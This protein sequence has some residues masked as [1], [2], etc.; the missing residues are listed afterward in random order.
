[1]LSTVYRITVYRITV[2]R[3]A[4]SRIAVLAAACVAAGSCACSPTT[5][6]LGSEPGGLRTSD[7]VDFSRQIRPLLSRNCFACHGPDTA[8][9]EADLR[10]DRFDSAT[11]ELP[12]GKRAIVPGRPDESALV[13]RIETSDLSERMPPAPEHDALSSEQVAVVR[14][15]IEQGAE[16]SKHWSFQPITSSP[17]PRV[18]RP[19]WTRGPIDQFILARLDLEAIQPSPEAD[20]ATLVR[21]LSLDLIGLPPTVLEVERFVGDQR[22]DAYERLVDRMLGEPGLGERWGRHWLDLARYA[23]SDGYLGDALRPY[24]WLYRDWVIDAINSDMPFDQF[25]IEQYAGDLLAGATR[26]QQI[27]TGFLRNSL[28]NTEAGVDREEYRVKSIVDRVSTLGSVWLGLS[29]AC[30]ECHAHKYDPISQAEFYGLFAF[31]N[32][33]DDVDLEVPLPVELAEM[34]AASER[35][36]PAPKAR[37]VSVRKERRPT[38]VHLRGDYR[39][40]GDA[41]QPGTLSVLPPLQASAS[42]ATRLDLARWLVDSANPL[43]PRVTVNQVWK[44]LFGQG[45]VTTE[46]DFGVNGRPPSHPELLDWLARELISRHWSRKDLIREI[47]CSATYRQS[48]VARPDLVELDPLNALLAKQNR[49]R[50]EAEAVRD[51]AL[52]ASGLLTRDIGGRSIRPPQPAYITSISRNID[53]EESLGAD[54]YRRGLYILLRRATPYP[55]QILFDAPESTVAC[56]RRQRTNSPLQALTLLNDPVFVEC[57]KAL[58]KRMT[59]AGSRSSDESFRDAYR[60]CLGRTPSDSELLRLKAAYTEIREHM[61]ADL[62]SAKLL[63]GAH[64]S[65]SQ[66]LRTLVEQATWIVLARIVMNLDE[67]ITRE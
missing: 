46:D 47:V 49:Y 54:R 28:D 43:S 67:F 16:Y 21:R 52:L 40:T 66:S 53:W 3:I 41:V 19:E 63:A 62:E 15:W 42:V 22:P 1:M 32:D 7:R 44:S 59:A 18:N 20:R 5:A 39:R 24:A 31:L 48:S 25:T 37:V 14:A 61:E 65:A 10:L 27:A 4:T 57:A 51:A 11:T 34:Q 56:T 23:D 30:A 35:V 50:L 13:Q 36:R 9:L 17:L 58:G 55:V 64:E 26:E 12:S 60:T 8:K 45:L 38:F 29:V 6:A 33:A 2:C